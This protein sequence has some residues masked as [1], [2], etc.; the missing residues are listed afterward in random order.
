M[1][2]PSTVEELHEADAALAEAAGHEGIVGEGAGLA[3][4]LAVEFEGGLGFV[5]NVG[6]LGHGHLHAEGHLVL[7]DAGFDLGVVEFLVMDTVE[8]AKVV[9]GFA[10]EVGV[11]TVGVVEVEDG[12]LAGTE[13]DALVFGR[14]EAGSPEAVVEGLAG[15]V[16]GHG[17]EGGQVGVFAAET[18]GKPGADG[19]AAGELEAGLEEGDGRVVI[20]GLGVHRANHADVI[21]HAGKVR[22]EVGVERLSALAHLLEVE[23][24]AGDGEGCLSGGHAGFALSVEDGGGDFLTVEFVELRFGIEEVHLRWAS[25]LEKID[26]ALGFGGEGCGILGREE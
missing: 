20:D 24:G 6:E 7:G 4:V 15:P 5:G 3:G 10:A 9:E 19:G 12:I 1:G 22:E 23:G 14:E 11:D 16:G 26:D 25:A 2:V 21:G 18:V 8:V 13:A 17:D